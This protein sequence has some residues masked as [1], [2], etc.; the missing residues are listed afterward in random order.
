LS[1]LFNPYSE[2]NKEILQSFS[3]DLS[4]LEDA[5]L[6]LDKV[7]A[8]ADFDGRTF[9]RILD[10]DPAFTD[11]YIDDMYKRKEWVSTHDD[12][13]DYSFIWKR[14]DYEKVMNRISQRVFEHEQDKHYFSYLSAFFGKEKNWAP[15]SHVTERQ[16]IFL[17]RLIFERHGDREFMLFLFSTIADFPADRRCFHITTFL[18]HN[19]N[20]EDFKELPLEPLIWSYSGSAVPMLQGK[21]DYYE[22]LIS[23]CNTIDFL[24]HRQF[25]EQK[26]S[27]LRTEIEREKKKDFTEDDG[28]LLMHER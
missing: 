5:Y 21:I 7:E 24:K 11:K 27:Y 26:I 19:N 23:V 10:S 6:T 16:D 15:D 3:E 28:I 20:F 13:R 4:L 12:H 2:I 8:H 9:S 1:Q 25:L 17:G 14:G 22:S 18:K